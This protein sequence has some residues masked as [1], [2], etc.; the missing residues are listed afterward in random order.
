MM[1]NGADGSIIIDTELDET[2]FNRGSKKMESAINGMNGKFSA[3]G[4]DMKSAV[5]SMN[6]A[7]QS[8]GNA[9]Q[10]NGDKFRSFFEAGNFDKAMG[11][12][13][14][15]AQSLV[16]QLT[17]IGTAEDAGVK[18]GAQMQKLE[19]QIEQTEQKLATLKAQMDEFG[20][21][22]FDSPEM[23]A[24]QEQ[25]DAVEQKYKEAQQ[26]LASLKEMGFQDEFLGGHIQRC[27]E[28]EEQLDA[29]GLKMAD[30]DEHGQGFTLNSDSADFQALL[31]TYRQL[32]EALETYKASLAQT[33]AEQEAAA[34]TAQNAAIQ[35]ER[36]AAVR[37]V[38][39]RLA[40]Q[41]KAAVGAGTAQQAD[42][43]PNIEGPANQA[44]GAL[45]GLDQ[46]LKSKGP[47]AAQASSGVS[48]FGSVLSRIGGVATQ[49]MAGIGR[50]AFKSVSYGAKTAA[51]GI[52]ALIS[53]LK[54]LRGSGQKAT[55]TNNGLVKAMTGF[56]RMLISR[57]KRTFI[58]TI[59]KDLQAGMQA[60]A[61]YSSSF[62]SAM[63]SMKNSMTGLSGNIGVLA[64]NLISAL[65]P[66][67]VT[68]IDWI[69]TA[70][71][72]LNAFFALL[73]GKGTFT[74]AKKGADNYA[75][76]LGGASGAAKELKNQVFGFDEL[77]KESGDSGGG[78]GGG[79]GG[80]M[81]FAEQAFDT[82]P[83]E[84]LDFM[85]SLKNAF[86]AGR[87][88][89]VGQ[90]VADGLDKVIKIMDN[91][92]NSKFRP[93]ATT[94]ASNIARILNGF[95]GSFDFTRLGM[96]IADGY[97]AIADTLN[98]FF[99]KFNWGLLAQR[100]ANGINGIFSRVDWDLIGETIG[101][102]LGG[103]ATLITGAIAGIN[104][105]TLGLGL[106]NGL[107]SMLSVINWNQLIS[108]LSTGFNGI[109]SGI[110]T[111]ISNVPW[112]DYATEFGTQM[113]TL[114]D[115]ID[116]D[117]LGA[118]LGDGFEALNQIF[119]GFLA[120][121]DWVTLGS[122]L[123]T[124]INSMF[125]AVDWPALGKMISDSAKG[126]IAGL[127]QVLIDTDWQAIGNDVATF[128]ASIDWSGLVSAI[129]TGIGAAL[130]GIGELLWG[131]I[132]PGWDS[133]VGWWNE[134]MSANGGDVV[135]T[136]LTGITTALS[137]IG[138]WCL[139]NIVKPFLGG[140]ESALGL[141]NG[142][143]LATAEQWWTSFKTGLITYIN[144]IGEVAT[145]IWTNLS[146][147]ITTAWAN[148]QSQ[149]IAPFNEAF[150][151]M[152]GAF[153][154]AGTIVSNVWEEI[155]AK[156]AEAWVNIQTALL[157]PFT[158]AFLLM[159]GAFANAGTIVSNVWDEIKT[160]LAEAWATAQQTVLAPFNEAFE[161]IKGAFANAG[162]IV[163][164][165]WAEIKAKLAET[166]TNIQS[167]VLAPFTEAWNLIKGAF[168]NA[169]SIVAN[170]WEDIKNGVT[171]NWQQVMNDVLAPFNEAFEL[172]KGA[173][174]NAGTIVA[175]VWEE[176]KAKL[177]EAW[178][179][180]QTALLVP[181]TEAFL[182]IKGAFAN[183]GSLV[184]NV[185]EEIKTKLV[186]AWV[187]IQTQVL[188][189]FTEAWNAI[190][191]AFANA[192]NLVANVWTDIKTALATG[193]T[194]IQ[195]QVLA[196]F[197]DAW[198]AI[199]GA[200]AN[201]AQIA[202]DLWEGLISGLSSGWTRLK[203]TIL[204]PFK[205]MWQAVKDFFGIASP[206]TE[207]Q[208]VADFIL[209][210]LIEGFN[211]A[212]SG[213]INTVKE[214]FGRIWDAIKAIFGFGKQ[215]D[216]AKEAKDAGKDIMT[217][218]KEG[219]T[220]DEETVKK[221]IK[222]AAKHALEALRTELG[223]PG[224]RGASTTTKTYGQNIIEGLESGIGEKATQQFFSGS[225]T[226]VFNN[227]K[228]AIRN[229]FGM[230][231]D[232]APSN[233]IKPAGESIP[234]GLEKGMTDKGTVNFFNA[235]T[236]KLA[237]NIKTACESVMKIS[238]GKAAYFNGIGNAI[239]QGVAKGITDK[240][241]IITKAAEDAAWKAYQ[242]AKK[243]LGIHSPSRVFA[244]I[245]EYSMLGWAK[246]MQSEEKSILQTVADLA[247]A[248]AKEF[249]PELALGEDSLSSAL[250]RITNQLSDVADVF[251]ACVNALTSMG[252]LNIPAIASG[253]YVP[254]KT[255][256]GSYNGSANE[257][258]LNQLAIAS[259]DRDEI[260][261]LLREVGRNIVNA[262]E[263]KNMDIDANS[264]ERAIT[265]LH[266]S[267]IRNYGGA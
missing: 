162:T 13:Q 102:G 47:D 2:G 263:R 172:V 215:S 150:E 20:N 159:K 157:V 51:K 240:Q 94:W 38:Q 63:S 86:A 173:F 28:L 36:E 96:T 112:L 261:S 205:D 253:A 175:N 105:N 57:I 138:E 210:G 204:Q 64:G 82:L 197:N 49:A 266:D 247:D 238:G 8:M 242:A 257:A 71:S 224:V 104:W 201:A 66:A 120:S 83:S 256:I 228:T 188:A 7:L 113:S 5:Q 100:F 216:E 212:V 235:S 265:S 70:I 19:Q 163:A 267:R 192:G 25:W 107:Q 118:T 48:A 91:W 29:I 22:R 56:K 198:T 214:V 26:E 191:G 221:A 65:A 133:V 114:L 23:T 186:E 245:G 27:K 170:V 147:E 78:G 14:K 142:T 250:N 54:S 89:E 6:S 196:P 109:V 61:K 24:L 131:L 184:A 9:A 233:N 202:T 125:A 43:T 226:T 167:Q 79:G 98:T 161:L 208:S 17:K 42:F 255:T 207:A 193:W 34:Q 69:S 243:K 10:Q 130:V 129:S 39:T 117:M 16:G 140:I 115:Q 209:Q 132:K 123:A 227:I 219:I 244:E 128:L 158:E 103:I 187:N 136:L 116:W 154:N 166:W 44:T 33:K 153:A 254:P 11:E 41:Q 101:H 137:G 179:N 185:W 95:N 90:I 50:L 234:L 148:F 217:G 59:F 84:V 4:K 30:M 195:T 52:G 77:N 145:S 220:G 190:K 18:P 67:L 211:N 139:N 264:L 203:N 239:A 241:S 229:A 15:Q 31:Q 32:A 37:D 222:D 249:A 181:F 258:L 80:A 141:E 68:I 146:T 149:V 144:T 134:T 35:A 21:V 262:I 237:E 182:L 53:K 171:V 73:S 122:N 183:A 252:G 88:E 155:K 62:N 76:S 160:K 119:W 251:A 236:R 106:A 97:N 189:P 194:T 55:L 246:G 74:V 124:G 259:K 143:I 99:T 232:N 169:G 72:Y 58:S 92:I 60:F 156:L 75:K 85:T 40:T 177:V 231:F 213:V 199:K 178:S 121:I 3:M 152:K 165:V 12:M 223:I 126:A 260:Y 45:K 93:F 174:A 111:F 110:S 108:N 230:G 46:E 168:A 81:Q 127:T 164:N 1:S 151:L 218:M 248:T 200:F 87:F 135:A 176:I 225:A 206:S 180:I